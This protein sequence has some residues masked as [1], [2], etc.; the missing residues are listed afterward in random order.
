M[1]SDTRPAADLMSAL[2]Q[3]VRTTRALNQRHAAAHSATGTPISLLRALR[4]E[5]VRVSEL[6]IRLSVAPSVVSR[7]IVPLE[8]AG[9]VERHREPDDGRACKIGLTA[10]GRQRMTEI[11]SGYVERITELLSAWDETE[12][13]EAAR[14]MRKLE[15]EMSQ[16]DFAALR[17][18]SLALTV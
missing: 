7:A 8:N 2:S 10:A 9:L 13:R 6:A 11:Q 5:D 4:D 17:L 3:L 12:V 16:A 18:P 1:D 14:L 15:A